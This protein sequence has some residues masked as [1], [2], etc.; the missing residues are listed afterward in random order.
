MINFIIFFGNGKVKTRL[1]DNRL[2]ASRAE[3]LDLTSAN[4]PCAET[5]GT[6]VAARTM[7]VGCRSHSH[8][9]TV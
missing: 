3:P 7:N 2:D 6:G 8:T 9:H 5:H 1:T 4:K